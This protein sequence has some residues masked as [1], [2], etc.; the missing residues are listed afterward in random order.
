VWLRNHVCDHSVWRN[1]ISWPIVNCWNSV[2]YYGVIVVEDIVYQI[3]SPFLIVLT[4]STQPNVHTRGGIETKG[5]KY[6]LSGKITTVL[7][8]LCSDVLKIL[9]I[10]P[11]PTHTAFMF[12]CFW[13]AVFISLDRISCLLF[14]I[15]TRYFLRNRTR[16]LYTVLI[17]FG[18]YFLMVILRNK[19]NSE[20]LRTLEMS[21]KFLCWRR[22]IRAHFQGSGLYVRW[23]KVVCSDYWVMSLH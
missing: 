10:P 13:K 17:N 19:S 2:D 11:S 20:S 6:Y 12:V 15:E 22:D 14:A 9:W 3:W 23:N 1:V 4:D 8:I 18:L 16:S 7:G 5:G 21:W